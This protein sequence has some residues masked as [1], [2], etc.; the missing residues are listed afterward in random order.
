MVKHLV[1]N[2]HT[3]WPVVFY[4]LSSAAVMFFLPEHLNS[5]MAVDRWPDL[6]WLNGQ[7]EA[8]CQ[9]LLRGKMPG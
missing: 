8:L 1:R 5:N 9:E 6:V 3:L 4:C 7:Q 2:V